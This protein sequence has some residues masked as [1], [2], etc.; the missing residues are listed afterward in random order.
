MP[1]YQVH[2]HDVLVIGAGGAGLRA[3]IAASA[4]G[5]SVGIVTKSLLGKAHTVMAEGGIAAALANVDER[6]NWKVHFADTMRGGQY[7]NDPRMAQLHAQE[8]PDCVRELEAWGAVFDRTRQGKI[9]Q[10]NFGGHKYPRL[11][12]VGDRTGLEM[13]RTLQDHGVHQGIDVHMECVIL[14]LLKDGDRVVG[15]FGYDRERGRFH[16]YPARAVVLATGGIGRAFKITSNSWEYTA[17]G[18]A[19]AYRAGAELRD[20]EFV[21]FHPTGMVWPPSVRGILVTEGVRGEGGILKNKEGRRFLFDDIP[22]LY[23]DQTADNPEEGWRYT[24]GDRSARRPPELLT[25]DHVARRIV[26]EV[27]EGR[28]SPH[29]GVFLDIAWIKEKLPHSAEHIK[30]KL[31]SMYHQFK[32]LADIDITKEP[33]EVGPTTHYMMGGVRVNPES[34]MSTVPGLFAAGE[35]AAGLHGANRL[36][37]NSL[38]DLLVFGKRAGA[39]AAAFARE[40]P[41]GR[42]NPDEA[43][44]AARQALGPFDRPS[45]ESPFLIQRGLQETMQD[46]VG[47]VRREEE[48]KKALDELQQ[49]KTRADRSGVMGNREYNPGWHTAVDLS[50]LLLISEAIARAAMERKESRGAHFRDDYPDRDDATGKC[51][52]VIRRG[53]GGEMQIRRESLPEMPAE[54]KEV[55]EEMK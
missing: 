4:A 11:A 38:S 24:Q 9:L 48:L 28:G 54:L 16:L 13:I 34:Q 22:P 19:L 17:D 41:A 45:G 47:I 53:V 43:E 39:H 6:D 30:R 44:A 10:R 15:A 14:T 51:N 7:L 31:P 40:H 33:M 23:K 29:G 12:H 18:L 42:V 20:M 49:L 8:A 21:Q 52:L 25:R 27:R 32:Q 55:I 50:N 36:G 35:C 3:A 46:L 1:E 26:R 37:G 2:E 5:V